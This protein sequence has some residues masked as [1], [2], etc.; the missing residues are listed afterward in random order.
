MTI[1]QIRRQSRLFPH[2][3]PGWVQKAF[4]QRGTSAK[5]GSSLSLL[6]PSLGERRVPNQRLACVCPLVRM[7]MLAIVPLQPCLQTRLE[8]HHAGK[9]PPTQKPPPQD[10]E[11]QVPLVQPRPV[12]RRE[13][14]HVL[15]AFVLQKRP[16]LR[17][18]P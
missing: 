9:H 3:R 12:D 17:P 1:S 10:A 4:K 11:K 16:S 14:E 2:V 8:I 7:R 6:S 13:V 5:P 18:G 15:V